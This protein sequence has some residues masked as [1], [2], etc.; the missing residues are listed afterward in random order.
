MN[1][2]A[3]SRVE[4]L[5]VISLEAMKKAGLIKKT[6]VPVKILGQGEIKGKFTVQANAFSQKAQEKIQSAGGRVEV[7]KC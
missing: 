7:V 6:D 2:S 5:E 1:L 4:N 3:L